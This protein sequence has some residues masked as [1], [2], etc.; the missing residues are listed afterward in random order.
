MTFDMN[1]KVG[2]DMSY[3]LTAAALVG[4]FRVYEVH[5]KSRDLPRDY[6]QLLVMAM[7]RLRTR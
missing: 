4:F 3:N 2:S 6:D 7:P 5:G 1:D